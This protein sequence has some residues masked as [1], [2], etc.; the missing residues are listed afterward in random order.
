M[1]NKNILIIGGTGQYG[2]TLSQ[3]LSKKK[4]IKFLLLRDLLKRSI[5]LIQNIQK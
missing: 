5:I 1:S 2:M 3:M 4:N